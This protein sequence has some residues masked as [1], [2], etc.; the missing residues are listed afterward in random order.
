MILNTAARLIFL[1]SRQT[2]SKAVAAR[3]VAS[4]AGSSLRP[5]VRTTS[6]CRQ[7]FAFKSTAMHPADD[8]AGRDAYDI[9]RTV[10]GTD[11]C[12]KMGLN[13]L[14]ITGP[15]KLFSN[16]TYQ[17]LF[18]HEVANKEGVVAKA[19]YGDTFTV[20]TGKFTGRSPLDR[21]I[22]LNPGS[23][24]AE[25]MDWNKIN[26]PTSPEVF[27]ELL[28]KA[29]AYFNTRETAYVF[30]GY[31][32]ANPETRK[33]IRFVH[34]MAWQQ[35]FVT[36]MFIRPE[37]REE[38]ENFEPD[39]TVIN[40]CSQVDEDWK[41]HNLHSDTAVVFNPEKKTAVIFGTWYGGENKKGIFSLMNFW[42]PLKGHFP[43][44]CSANVG[45]DGDVCL[46]FGLSGTG[47]TTLSADPHRALIGDDEHGWDDH[48]VFNFEGG[49]YA[50]TINLSEKTEPDIYR[51]I[52]TDA[53]LENVK[54]REDGT[55]DY[56]DTSKT[57]NGRVSYPIFHIP[58]YHKPQMAGHP[59]NIIFLTCDAYGVMPPVARLT[60]EQAMYH[61]L[62][63]YTAKVAGTERGIKEPTATFSTCF[64]AAFMTHHPTRYADLLREKLE[65][66]GSHAYLVNS[67]WSG[68]PYGEGKRMSI[69]TTRACIDAILDGS[70]HDAEFVKDPIF[71]F[72]V[73]KA[74]HDV[75]GVL[76]PKSTWKDPAAY[77]KMALHLAK[78]F[79]EN[80]KNYEGR[81]TVDYTKFGPQ[82]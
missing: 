5:T 14:G 67:G 18:D 45:K 32:G 4:L 1:Q 69:D 76:D 7:Q 40:C 9:A 64:G 12:L 72:E 29:V 8:T 63:G 33:K 27:D 35:H 56:F 3:S 2:L 25:H 31:C 28:E 41:R 71:G 73:P 57:E 51:A 11:A 74:L 24:T 66:H 22:V 13:R 77:D 16:L 58:G 53:L 62:S 55:P 78:L 68:G 19:E 44:H 10:E 17:E 60:P 38:I 20:D 79:K 30:D 46:F 43:M 6:P 15:T 23:E 49:C 26:Q 48:G 50:K 36:N 59:N 37:T 21:W 34:E 82:I 65:K 80:F 70:I 42:L 81:G 47:K 61:F 54:I 52:K 39:F 75:G